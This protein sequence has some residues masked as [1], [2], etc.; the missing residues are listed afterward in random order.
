MWIHILINFWFRADLNQFTCV[1][2]NKFSVQEEEKKLSMYVERGNNTKSIQQIKENT[3]L[4]RVD[5]HLSSTPTT[6]AT[7]PPPA[8]SPT[9]QSRLVW[10]DKTI[11]LGKQ[12]INPPPKKKQKHLASSSKTKKNF[13]FFFQTSKKKMGSLVL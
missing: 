9:M 10:Q 8:N 7:D 2:K 3:N 4:L 13:F 1:A 6:T 11:F 5:C 12:P